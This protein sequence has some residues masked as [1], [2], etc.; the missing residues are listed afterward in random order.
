M[1]DVAIVGGGPAGL[2]AA[3]VLGRCRRSVLVYDEGKPRNA[4][5]RGVHGFLGHDGIAPGA[6]R[7]RARAELSPYAVELRAVRVT[8]AER[9]PGGFELTD[10]NGESARARRLL[11]ATGVTDV[12]PD[13]PGARELYARGIYPCAYCD[14]WE[15]RDRA[16]GAYGSGPSS[17]E[18]ALGLTTWSRD[19][20]LFS[21]GPADLDPSARA[22]L[23][24][25]RV[26]LR[27][28]R[29]EAFE[30]DDVGLR[31]VLL[32]GGIRVPRDAIFLHLGQRQRSPLAEMLG[33]SFEDGDF[34]ETGEKQKTRVAGVYLAGD[35][36][37]DVKFAIVAAAQG[38]RAAHDINQTLREEDTP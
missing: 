22:R 12:L 11:L 19:V 35:A 15:L 29:I 1:H 24:R 5:S 28:E 6:L 2:T 32:E 25:N 26:W 13:V 34:A 21:N 30:G 3:L 14:G 10:A 20:I 23:T 8:R 33:C 16:L 4:R 36:S 7:E 37:H 38:A 27:E 18:A 31:D 9:V 17:A